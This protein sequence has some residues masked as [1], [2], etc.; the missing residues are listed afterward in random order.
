[1]KNLFLFLGV[2][3]S[4]FVFVL[5]VNISNV[6][7]LIYGINEHQL[8]T[9]DVAPIK[10]LGVSMQRIGFDWGKIEESKGVFDFTKVDNAFKIAKDNNIK[11]LGLLGYTAK[12]ASSDPSG[13]EDKMYPPRNF[14]DY[15]NFVG[16]MVERY[17]EVKYWEVWNEPNIP[18]FWKPTPNATEY[19]RLL[20]GAY[21][22][23]KQKNPDAKVVL[24][25]MAGTDVAFLKKI[26]DAG[27]KNY[28]D[29][30]AIHPYRSASPTEVSTWSGKTLQGEL[31][32]LKKLMSDYG[33]SS[34]KIWITEIGYSTKSA[35]NWTY[36]V[37]ETKQAEYLKSFFDIIK[38]YTSIEAVFWY[39][40]RDPCDSLANNPDWQHCGL[41]ILNYDYS[42]KEA[43]T[44]LKEIINPAGGNSKAT[45]FIFTKNLILGSDNEEVRQLQIILNSDPDTAIIASG[46]KGN[47]TKGKEVTYFGNATKEAVQKF[48]KK[49]G[50][51]PVNGFV[52]ALTRE[53][54][55]LL[56]AGNLVVDPSPEPNANTVLPPDPIPSN[57]PAAPTV[58]NYV[59]TK[60][61]TLGSDNEDV[62]QLQI[63]LNS[64]PDTA[65]IAIGPKGHGTTGK[66]VTYFGVA[67]ENAVSKFQKKYGIAPAGGFVGPSTRNVLNSF[68]KK[69]SFNITESNQIDLRVNGDGTGDGKT[70]IFD[71]STNAKKNFTVSWLASGSLSG[72]KGLS[73]SAVSNWNGD[74]KSL[75]GT[76]T[77]E[78]GNINATTTLSLVCTSQTGEITAQVKIDRTPAFL[79]RSGP[80]SGTVSVNFTIDDKANYLGTSTTHFLKWNTTNA[81]SC[82]ASSIPKLSRWDNN[83]KY[84]SG[85]EFVQLPVGTTNISLKCNNAKGV[86][87]E[88]T[89]KAEINSSTYVAPPAVDNGED[90]IKIKSPIVGANVERNEWTPINFVVKSGFSTA[91][92]INARLIGP[93][94]GVQND[95]YLGQF[96][97]DLNGIPFNCA[98]AQADTDRMMLCDG[99][100]LKFR[101]LAG[102]T[103]GKYQIKFINAPTNVNHIDESWIG[104]EF[105]LVK[106][107]GITNPVCPQFVPPAPGWCST[108]TIVAQPKDANGCEVP[109]KCV[110]DSVTCTSFTYTPW[111]DCVNGT[112]TREKATKTPAGC[113]GGGPELSRTCTV[114]PVTCTSF[115]YTPWSACVNG[116]QTR[117]KA[118][119]TPTGCTGG[120]PVLT[121][122]CTASSVTCT[123]FTYTPWSDCINGTQ[124]REK[125]TKTPAGCTGGGPILSQPC[126]VPAVTCTSFTYTPWSACVNGT[127]TREKATKTPTGCTGGSPVLSRSCSVEPVTCTSFTYTDWSTCVDG[128]QT[129]TKASKTPAGC[130]GGGPVLTQSCTSVVPPVI[131]T[132]FTY[133]A[134]SSCVNGQQTRTK[135]SKT[136]AGCTG[137]QPKLVRSCTTSMNTTVKNTATV[138]DT[139]IW[140]SIKSLFKR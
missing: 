19:V 120:G 103:L 129:R 16:K 91:T 138:S 99:T 45:S 17:P 79:L 106:N 15:F 112:Q 39:E 24:A 69:D 108:G 133:S 111:S 33:D 128:Q 122:S 119:K 134:W 107:D 6:Q 73:N 78:V 127:Q 31:D 90:K 14:Q 62:R 38:N 102:T 84:N 74:K 54:L 66:E 23:I 77:I 42:P 139:G 9:K 26:Y 125:A 12:W 4:T 10:E 89:L 50:I 67:T 81:V 75:T 48:Q 5:S 21:A 29:I 124:T 8:Y 65:I 93:I 43:F 40:L 13:A 55:N 46:P 20:K 126:T 98:M 72:C 58:F 95:L 7:A 83:S 59:F 96:S 41:G 117:E 2:I 27:G 85:I 118:T 86:I 140:N 1:M 35:K 100:G 11:I 70:T 131:C 132:S 116:I 109:P 52:R 94:G 68:K 28:F 123:S 87:T 22:V 76:E 18:S 110:T 32:G 71:T 137:G 101:A 36:S 115:T 114:N 64:D 136:P 25:G 56:L 104:P 121:Q 49:Y 34:K 82:I 135:T 30:M 113:T 44:A 3:V 37:T 130:T 47:G 61:L 60:N 80:P 63:I 105:N 57:A 88:S 51:L 97:T 53:K 92:R